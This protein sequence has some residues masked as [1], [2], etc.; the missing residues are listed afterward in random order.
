MLVAVGCIHTG[1]TKKTLPNSRGRSVDAISCVSLDHFFEGERDGCV[2][3][4]HLEGRGW[5]S[6]RL[7]GSHCEVRLKKECGYL[8]P[9]CVGTLSDTAAVVEAAGAGARR[10]FF[11]HHMLVCYAL[12]VRWSHTESKVVLSAVAIAFLW[13]D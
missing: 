12:P 1:G 11:L 6:F 9:T 13:T 2:D 7:T 10:R 3:R 5:S 8:V 4:M